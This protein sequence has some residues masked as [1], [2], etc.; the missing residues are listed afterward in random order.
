MSV[1]QIHGTSIVE[2]L[3]VL[4]NMHQ[5]KVG[6]MKFASVQ[7]AGDYWSYQIETGGESLQYDSKPFLNGAPELDYFVTL[8]DLKR[9]LR[10][11][12]LDE[13]ETAEIVAAFE[14]SYCTV[15]HMNFLPNDKPRNRTCD[16]PSEKFNKY[17]R[18]I[19]WIIISNY[20]PHAF[21]EYF[22]AFVTLNEP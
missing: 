6:A 11:N 2:H 13:Y 8:E 16:F 4:G 18:A 12:Q 1:I 3:I 10:D 21:V 15:Y 20:Y 14:G 17:A 22:P 5:F 7:S 19:S 9:N